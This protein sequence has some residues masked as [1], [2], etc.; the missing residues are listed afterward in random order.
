MFL[1]LLTNIFFSFCFSSVRKKNTH[2]IIINRQNRSG[3]LISITVTLFWHSTEYFWYCVPTYYSLLDR[4]S[5]MFKRTNINLLTYFQV[6][7]ANVYK[8]YRKQPLD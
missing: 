1:R 6:Q 8:S 2:A 5:V 4:A 3:Q 7:V